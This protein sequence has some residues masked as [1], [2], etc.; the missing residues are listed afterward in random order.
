MDEL[1]KCSQEQL[2]DKPSRGGWSLLDVVEHLM[3]G[4]HVVLK[5]LP[6]PSQLREEKPSF[7]DRINSWLVLGILRAGIRVKVP[8]SSME[9]NGRTTLQEVRNKWDKS[10]A[11]LKAYISDLDHKKAHATVFSHPVSGP[12]TISQLLTLSEAHFDSHTRKI[13]I[14][15]KH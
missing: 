9:P 10:Q 11:W 13:K 1:S 5:G 14:K 7:R 3:L 8:S 4:E 2:T 15:L 12:L 6:K